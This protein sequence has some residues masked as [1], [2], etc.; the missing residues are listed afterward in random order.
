MTVEDT[1]AIELTNQ[2]VFDSLQTLESIPVHLL[3]GGHGGGVALLE[4][5]DDFL[6]AG[7]HLEADPLRRPR[8]LGLRG[9][10][11][12]SGVVSHGIEDTVGL[13][14]SHLRVSGALGVSATGSQQGGCVPEGLLALVILEGCVNE[15]TTE[16]TIHLKKDISTGGPDHR[17]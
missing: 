6:T 16:M 13:G 4:L 10:I 12:P 11:G 5:L 3:H 7:L 1:A 2:S 14:D 8:H 15:G 9:V 17:S